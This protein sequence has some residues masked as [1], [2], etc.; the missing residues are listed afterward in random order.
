MATLMVSTP[1]RSSEYTRYAE[2]NTYAMLDTWVR[3]SNYC[4]LQSLR[5]GYRLPRQWLSPY[6]ISSVTLSLEGRNLAV[7]ASDYDNY[8]DPETMGNPYAQPIA[9]SFIFGLNVNF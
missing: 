5:L 4:R 2:Y 6:G 7:I 8:L 9:R 1:E 3:S